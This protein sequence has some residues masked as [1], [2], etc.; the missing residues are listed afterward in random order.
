MSALISLL[1]FIAVVVLVAYVVIWALETLLG[2]IFPGQIQAI[3]KVIV[4]LVALGVIVQ[5]VLPFIGN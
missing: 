1:I 3:V 2:T 4:V 5:H